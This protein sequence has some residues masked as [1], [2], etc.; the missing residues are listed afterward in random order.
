[1]SLLQRVEAAKLGITLPTEAGSGVAPGTPVVAVPVERPAA[2]VLPTPARPRISVREQALLDLRARL[3]DQV[4][5]AWAQLL[6]L[7]N[8]TEIRRRIATIV[9]ETLVVAA[10]EH[11]LY[12]TA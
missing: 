12:L 1:M 4:L 11:D 6:D 5:D 7:S 10:R 8:V 2:P 9:D 3:A